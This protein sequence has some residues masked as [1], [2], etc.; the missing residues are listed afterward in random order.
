MIP[1][2]LAIDYAARIASI[3]REEELRR[4]FDPGEFRTLTIV[5]RNRVR[6]RFNALRIA[7]LRRCQTELG[8]SQSEMGRSMGIDQ[9]QISRILRRAAA[10][11]AAKEAA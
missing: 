2:A 4:G 1:R 11:A 5:Q 8:M 9:A 3:I 10:K 7:I 6:G